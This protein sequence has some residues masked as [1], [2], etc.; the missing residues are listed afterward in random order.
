MSLVSKIK[1]C[2][3]I[4]EF[5]FEILLK[6][7][8]SF[9]LYYRIYHFKVF[10]KSIS[11]DPRNIIQAINTRLTI[12]HSKGTIIIKGGM[13]EN[14]AAL[15]LHYRF[16]RLF[17]SKAISTV[18]SVSSNLEFR[19]FTDYRWKVLLYWVKKL[20]ISIIIKASSHTQTLFHLIILKCTNYNISTSYRRQKLNINNCTEAFEFYC[21]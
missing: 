17:N 18:L 2:G 21:N 16:I 4:N 19:P 14:D 5:I 6:F 11:L 20:N 10:F 12:V 7:D 8:K 1:T 15:D 9:E 3:N 13:V